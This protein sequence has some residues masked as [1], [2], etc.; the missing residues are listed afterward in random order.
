VAQDVGAVDVV[1]LQILLDGVLP[2]VQDKEIESVM[3]ALKESN[4]LT[5]NGW[6]CFKGDKPGRSDSYG[7]EHCQGTEDRVFRRVEDIHK[8]IVTAE[9]GDNSVQSFLTLLVHGDQTATTDWPNATRPD[10]TLHLTESSVP[11][12]CRAGERY[13]V[14]H[15][16]VVSYFEVKLLDNDA[17]FHDVSKQTCC[18]HL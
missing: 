13:R 6:E 15:A 14:D 10:A 2:T 16:D 3:A 18:T 4:V 8:A 7:P 9:K 5:A 12:V 1:S 11:F 17:N